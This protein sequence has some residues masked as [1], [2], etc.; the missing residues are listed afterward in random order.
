MNRYLWQECAEPTELVSAQ[1]EQ[2][3]SSA[4]TAQAEVPPPKLRSM[5]VDVTPVRQAPSKGKAGR[6]DRS[7]RRVS[8]YPNML[9]Q[10]IMEESTQDLDAFEDEKCQLSRYCCFWHTTSCT[11]M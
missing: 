11:C 5:S 9:D 4:I 6:H 7:G 10:P 3:V 8:V 2:S 1:Y